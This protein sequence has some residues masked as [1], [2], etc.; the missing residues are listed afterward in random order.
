MRFLFTMSPATDLDAAVG[1]YAELGFTELWRPGDGTA[2]LAGPGS[3]IGDVMVETG[4]AE[5][6]AGSGPVYEVGSVD[7]FHDANPD[8]DYVLAP[9]DVPTGRYAIFTDSGGNAVRVIDFSD[10]GFA[11][12]RLFRSA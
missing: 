9:R 6:A 8:L 1:F 5:L 7:R 11:E 12:H 3:P 10:L 2:L 4:P